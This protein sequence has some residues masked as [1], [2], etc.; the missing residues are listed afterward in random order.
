M[1]WLLFQG[2]GE[3][4]KI[5]TS[6]LIMAIVGGAI[7]TQLEGM[8][9][10]IVDNLRLGGANIPPGINMAYLVPMLCF[11]FIAFYANNVGK[12]KLKPV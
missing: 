8:V 12:E 6:G 9:S 2:L 3:D 11:V 5:A 10:T 4:T 7:I 1:D